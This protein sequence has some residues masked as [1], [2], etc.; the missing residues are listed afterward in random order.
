ME[1]LSAPLLS[2]AIRNGCMKSYDQD[3]I[4]IFNKIFAPTVSEPINKSAL[5]YPSAGL[6]LIT[7]IILGLPYCIHFY[8]YEWY[9]ERL[10][11]DNSLIDNIFSILS[12]IDGIEIENSNWVASNNKE[13]LIKF[14]SYGIE[15][16]AHWVH[17]DNKD[18]LNKDVILKFYFHRG[19][20]Y[21]EGG[22]GQFWDSELLPQLI[23][24][25]PQG[26]RSLFVTDGEPGGL[27]FELKKISHEFER[28]GRTRSIKY[29]Y[30]SLFNLKMYN[31][32]IY[33]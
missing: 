32:Q 29:Y 7:P 22:S 4:R 6:D 10:L 18:F 12:N 3:L 14:H 16:T 26:V 33:E 20:S 31:H 21:G 8:F 11:Q 30:G 15:R 13:H 17:K 24:M 1:Y 27:S 25:I 19:D 9:P 28:F 23:N 2:K 5:F